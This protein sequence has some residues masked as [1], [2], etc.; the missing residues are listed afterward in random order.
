[1]ETMRQEVRR[2]R[3]SV[4]DTVGQFFKCSHYSMNRKDFRRIFHRFGRTDGLS[5]ES[6]RPTAY[7]GARFIRL[8]EGN[9]NR[10]RGWRCLSDISYGRLAICFATPRTIGFRTDHSSQSDGS[11][12]LFGAVGTFTKNVSPVRASISDTVQAQVAGVWPLSVLCSY[13]KPMHFSSAAVQSATALPVAP[14]RVRSS[15]L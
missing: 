13:Q 2:R 11:A 15:T 5:R 6:G 4:S 14:L 3:F 7:G 9:K 8:V 12:T 1:M 10:H